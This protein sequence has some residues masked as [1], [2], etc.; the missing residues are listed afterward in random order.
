MRSRLSEAISD[1]VNILRAREVAG[2]RLGEPFE[3][4]AKDIAEP[5]FKFA[6]LRS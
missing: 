5:V 1:D 4:V 3:A 6:M 2:F